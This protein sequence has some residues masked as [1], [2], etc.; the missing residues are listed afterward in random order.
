MARSVLPT[1]AG[2]KFHSSPSGLRASWTQGGTRPRSSS[3][4]LKARPRCARRLRRG[5]AAA[6]LFGSADMPTTY[7]EAP[8]DFACLAAA[9]F[10]QR[11]MLNRVELVFAT[12]LEGAFTKPR[13]SAALSDML[14]RRAGFTCSV[15]CARRSRRARAKAPKP[16]RT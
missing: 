12:P 4:R 8:L 9:F 10:T 6:S 15:F 7:R 16:Q 11:G 1:V 14:E 2:H 3:T 13:A 5:A